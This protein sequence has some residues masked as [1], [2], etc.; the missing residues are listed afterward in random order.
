MAV[1]D[2]GPNTVPTNASITINVL[3][4]DSGNGG[5]LDPASVQVV[6]GSVTDGTA[7]ANPTP[8][9]I[10]A[11]VPVVAGAWAVNVKGAAACPLA[12]PGNT[13]VSVQ[14]AQGTKVSN[15]PLA[16]Q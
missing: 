15:V 14:S 9:R 10:V 3:T 8:A 16:V 11:T 5:T 6:P 1:A 7:A 2:P 12:A 4:S 13:L